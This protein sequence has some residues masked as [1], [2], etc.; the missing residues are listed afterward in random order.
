M[1]L[2]G[3]LGVASTSFTGTPIAQAGAG[4]LLVMPSPYFYSQHREIVALA[5][6][7]KLPAIYE[8][9]EIA[10]AGGLMAYG[11]SVR[12]LFN[13]RRSYAAAS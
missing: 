4:A 8:W 5:A 2:I 12:A 7:Y 3:F 9:G 6:R 10:Q 1:L 11:D 13:R